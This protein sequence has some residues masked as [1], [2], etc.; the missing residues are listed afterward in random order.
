MDPALCGLFRLHPGCPVSA[1]RRAGGGWRGACR[2]RRVSRGVQVGRPAEQRA[3][4][5][6][7]HQS[8]GWA[9]RVLLASPAS[10]HQRREL[11]RWRV[12]PC[13]CP[14]LGSMDSIKCQMHPALC[15]RYR[16]YLYLLHTAANFAAGGSRS[17]SSS[18]WQQ[19]VAAGAVGRAAPRS[20]NISQGRPG[21][22]H[23]PRAWS[24]ERAASRL[25]GAA[26]TSAQARMMMSRAASSLPCQPRVASSMQSAWKQI[27]SQGQTLTQRT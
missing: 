4:G 18:R 1:G 24:M 23:G 15:D 16:V 21:K 5:R 3:H 6:Q 17:S 22:W 10:P 13:S 19:P 14:G 26:I 20:S 9:P 2:G 25:C 11:P 12:P 8:A 7:T 27:N